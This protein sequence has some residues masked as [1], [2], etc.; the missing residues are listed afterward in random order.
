MS[1]VSTRDAQDEM[2]DL[3]GAAG[4]VAAV[5]VGGAAGCFKR[6]VQMDVSKALR[7]EV[8]EG[9]IVSTIHFSFAWSQINM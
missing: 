4:L 1:G 2:E 9:A 7:L 5:L 3:E 6:P 8:F